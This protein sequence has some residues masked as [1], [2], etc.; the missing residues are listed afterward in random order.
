M[1]KELIIKEDLEKKLG[2]KVVFL[3]NLNLDIEKLSYKLKDYEKDSILLY[4]V[5]SIDKSNKKF[6]MSKL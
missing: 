3:E 5:F 2:V 4:T 6:P 1:F